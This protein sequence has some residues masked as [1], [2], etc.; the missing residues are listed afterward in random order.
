[1]NRLVVLFIL[2]LSS[3]TPN[4]YQ[5]LWSNYDWTVN[6]DTIGKKKYLITYR[7]FSDDQQTDSLKITT[8][9]RKVLEAIKFFNDSQYTVLYYYRLHNNKVKTSTTYVNNAGDYYAIEYYCTG[10]IKSRV[11]YQNNYLNGQTD[12]YWRNSNLRERHFYIRD[13]LE[14]IYF[15]NRKGE[16]RSC[17]G[18]TPNP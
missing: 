1:M 4:I 11:K 14:K 10:K 12:L 17:L 3:C 16:Y 13:S 2:V 15:Y 6:R 9:G 18:C 5:E 7:S 8:R